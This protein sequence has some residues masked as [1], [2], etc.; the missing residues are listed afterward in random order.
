[1]KILRRVI[2]LAAVLSLTGCSQSIHENEPLSVKQEG[3]GTEE[4]EEVSDEEVSMPEGAPSPRDGNEESSFWFQM[5]TF[6]GDTLGND[7]DGGRLQSGSMKTGDKA[8]LVKSDGTSYETSVQK[9]ALYDAEDR[10]NPIR[11][12][13]GR[14]FP[15][16]RLA[17]RNRIRSIPVW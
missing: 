15:D 12:R 7:F 8:V 14:R 9:I 11:D 3:T 4:Q 6:Y 2:I 13:S 5:T 10:I 1:M 16:I 17:G